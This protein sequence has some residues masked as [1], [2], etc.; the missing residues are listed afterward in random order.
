[1]VWCV[2]A[3]EQVLVW[4]SLTVKHGQLQFALGQLG[5]L[6]ACIRVSMFVREHESKFFCFRGIDFEDDNVMNEKCF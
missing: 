1:M 6:A 2:I 3:L 5:W 4:D